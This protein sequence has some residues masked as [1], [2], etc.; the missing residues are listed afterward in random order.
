[1]DEGIGKIKKKIEQGKELSF[2]V[3]PGGLVA[4][5][6]RVYLLE[7]KVLKNE[8]LKEAHKYRFATHPGST[9]MY[10]DLKEYY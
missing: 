2:Q 8:I 6:K 4:I 3:L 5:G 9:K 10:K 1:M 7:S